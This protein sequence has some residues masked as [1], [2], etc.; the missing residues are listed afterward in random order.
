MNK[1]IGEGT[2]GCVHEP[3][4]K[5]KYKKNVNYDDKISKIMKKRNAKD[6]LDEYEKITKI[7]PMKDFYLGKP[8]ECFPKIDIKNKKAINKCDSF[9]ERDINS[10]KL[11]IMK[12]GGNSLEKYGKI[13][14]DRKATRVN[15]KK[16][17]LYLIELHRLFYGLREM[18]ENNIIH[19]DLKPHNIVYN[20]NETR[21]NFIDFGL[22]DDKLNI[23]DQA[24]RSDYN[25]G[26]PYWYFPMELMFL[27]KNNYNFI[28]NMPSDKRRN[29][30]TKLFDKN[31]QDMNAHSKIFYDYLPKTIN[32]NG[33]NENL[34]AYNLQ[35]LIKSI[36][37]N[38]N[39]NNYNEFL[40]KSLNTIDIYGTGVAL[41]F[42]LKK[43]KH[44]I[45][46]ELNKQLEE[47]FYSMVNADVY[48]RIT[49]DEL[50]NKYETILEQSILK[51]HNYHFVNNKIRQKSSLLS[52]VYTKINNE[53]KSF[54]LTAEKLKLKT[55]V[56]DKNCPPEKEL[57]PSTKRCVKKCRPNYTRNKKFRCVNKTRK[58]P[59][60]ML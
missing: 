4:L 40:E 27:N 14:Q 20:E 58:S 60:K 46:T 56:P 38:I 54:K 23:I 39:H 47:L 24:K 51:K 41:L 31:F 11:L 52:N 37:F 1:V 22:M 59:Y 53:I 33:K 43:G 35:N 16:M 7:D 18:I 25:L 34:Q 50:L 42:I 48:K 21:L 9:N 29:Y 10:Y 28:A 49:I 57:N 13:L 55:R 30:I 26:I 19:H 5:C 36:T 45:Q 15:V 8:T 2:Y 17:E 44:L 3:S 12:N 32:I 6:E